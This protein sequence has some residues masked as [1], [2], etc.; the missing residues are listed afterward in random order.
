[1]FTIYLRGIVNSSSAHKVHF[2]AIGLILSRILELVFILL[3]I[4][5]IYI[6][7]GFLFICCVC[8]SSVFL[9][10]IRVGIW[11][12]WLPFVGVSILFI[13]TQIPIRISLILVW[14]FNLISIWSNKITNCFVGLL[15]ILLLSLVVYI[16]VS[17]EGYVDARILIWDRIRIVSCRWEYF[18]NWFNILFRNSSVFLVLLG[19]LDGKDT[20]I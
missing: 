11:S 13:R 1:M 4:L 7:L 16:N 6:N 12:W 8:V 5:L 15:L 10:I 3:T 17:F 2:F 19:L 9:V 18:L 20:L 14:N